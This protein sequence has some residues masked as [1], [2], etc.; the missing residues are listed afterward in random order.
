[1]CA[2]CADD[3][4]LLALPRPKSS[5]SWWSTVVELRAGHQSL[6]RLQNLERLTALQSADFS[7][8][9]ISS[10]QGL[11]VCTSLTE[12]NLRVSF[13]HHCP[14]T[15]RRVHTSACSPS[16]ECFTI[17]HPEHN[18]HTLLTGLAQ[19]PWQCIELDARVRCRTISSCIWR[20][21]FACQAC[22]AWTWGKT[23]S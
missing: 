9:A 18:C 17:V 6:R 22:R 5:D 1:M 16:Q 11:Q 8:N 10:I 20:G 14:V 19:Y 13:I 23:T 4:G 21:W 15:T 12:L 7:N 2:L 3:N